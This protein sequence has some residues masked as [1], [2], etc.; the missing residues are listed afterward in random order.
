MSADTADTSTIPLLLAFWTDGH[1]S[2]R[3]PAFVCALGMTLCI[4]KVILL[5]LHTSSLLKQMINGM[6]YGYHSAFHI[7]I[8]LPKEQHNARTET[9]SL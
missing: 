5:Y 9:C 7:L 4:L 8:R 1:G 6:I 3:L 2:Y